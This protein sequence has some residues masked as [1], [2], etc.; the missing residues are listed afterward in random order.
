MK[1]R[2][3]YIRSTL[4]L[5]L[6]L[7]LVFPALLALSILACTSRQTEPS[8]IATTI[9]PLGTVLSR[10]N[11][12][13]NKAVT[14]NVEP[15]NSIATAKHVSLGMRIRGELE[16]D[17]DADVFAFD[18]VIGKT[19]Q[20][21][22][23]D[24]FHTNLSASVTDELSNTVAN[25]PNRWYKDDRHDCWGNL[26]FLDQMRWQAESNGTHYLRISANPDGDPTFGKYSF[27]IDDYDSFDDHPNLASEATLI[28]VGTTTDGTI[29]W[30]RDADHFRLIAEPGYTYTFA[31]KSIAPEGL[32][33]DV[34]DAENRPLPLTPGRYLFAV[35]QLP[36]KYAPIKPYPESTLQTNCTKIVSN[37]GEY[38]R[39]GPYRDEAT[40]E[41][42][43]PNEYFIT[44]SQNE[45]SNPI[46]YTL[47]LDSH[48]SEDVGET[49]E[50]ASDFNLN[51]IV[52][53][54]VGFLYDADLFRFRA[55]AEKAYQ[56]EFNLTG[57]WKPEISIL[58][59]DDGQL[60]MRRKLFER[61]Y[62]WRFKDDYHD[63]DA[64]RQLTGAF[65]AQETG[66]VYLIVASPAAMPKN[67]AYQFS[68]KPLEAFTDTDDSIELS[69]GQ[70]HQGTIDFV[71]DEDFFHFHVEE[72]KRFLVRIEFPFYHDP[73]TH[74][75]FDD[76]S[77][78]EINSLS[79]HSG[80][81]PRRTEY[82]TSGAT[83]MLHILV[84]DTNRANYTISV[85]ELIR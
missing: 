32:R 22:I 53:S 46:Q 24:D 38:P 73:V 59:L 6:V 31:T 76:E 15:G 16:T 14:A 33:L 54:D 41:S 20:V 8:Q 9:D 45:A 60:T 13:A 75:W 63:D 42:P 55:V 35:T 74:V 18:A 36:P 47:S 7:P 84:S 51:E 81:G 3:R 79:F 27:E 68:V 70:E 37:R 72:G 49:P 34:V 66:D 77:E 19:Y 30:G 40:F 64:K 62:H 28:E 83:G 65:V 5:F 71:E 56:L 78:S 50:H 67:G 44:V 29:E 39:R 11:E 26:P 48:Q 43:K 85:I 61:D 82:R 57:N 21:N 58:Y 69:I 80:P 23:K 17:T 1:V 10:P 4:V 2:N 12:P 52:E 25:R